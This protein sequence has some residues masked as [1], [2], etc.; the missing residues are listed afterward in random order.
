MQSSNKDIFWSWLSCHLTALFDKPRD[1]SEQHFH[2]HHHRAPLCPTVHCPTHMLLNAPLKIS[3]KF[4]AF[5]PKS[6]FYL[7][8]EQKML[9]KKW[10]E[11]IFYICGMSLLLQKHR[12]LIDIMY[13]STEIWA[14][15]TRPCMATAL[16][17]R[18][19]LIFTH[20]HSQT[21][22]QICTTG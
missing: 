15:R 11:L 17:G 12:R 10:E 14:A 7:Q 19:L 6:K 2:L 13:I 21:L 4:K 8:N 16:P 20:K 9:R 1:Q 18:D 22:H 5:W 3:I